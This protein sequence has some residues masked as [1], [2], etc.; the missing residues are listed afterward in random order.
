MVRSC[1]WNVLC[2]PCLWGIKILTL[3]FFF[4]RVVP[5]PQIS[6]FRKVK[7]IENKVLGEKKQKRERNNHYAVLIL[8]AEYVPQSL[9]KQPCLVGRVGS[10]PL[11]QPAEILRTKSLGSSDVIGPNVEIIW[12]FCIPR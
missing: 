10:Q 1:D 9:D 2:S 7:I 11:E 5:I 6:S 4:E 12:G 8:E 3:T